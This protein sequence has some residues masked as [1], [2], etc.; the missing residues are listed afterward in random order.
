MSAN[1]PRMAPTDRPTSAPAAKPPGG[2]ARRCRRRPSGRRLPGAAAAANHGARAERATRKVFEACL[3]CLKLF[4]AR[5]RPPP[6]HL[7]VKP[8]TFPS[9]FFL[10]HELTRTQRGFGLVS[11][12]QRRQR[13]STISRSTRFSIEECHARKLKQRARTTSTRCVEHGCA[14]SAP[15]R[16]GGGLLPA[17][18]HWGVH[19]DRATFL[20]RSRPPGQIAGGWPAAIS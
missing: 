18:L 5:S 13:G 16:A 4:I 2:A 8:T 14:P 15:A 7:L 19:C 9:F 10:S 6:R 20:Y 11:L 3:N 1:G 17:S 12:V